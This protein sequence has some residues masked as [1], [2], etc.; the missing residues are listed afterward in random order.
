[1]SKSTVQ[2]PSSVNEAESEAGLAA[3]GGSECG[4]C[5]NPL[6]KEE[7]EYPWMSPHGESVCERCEFDNYHFRCCICD[8]HELKEHQH[9][10]LAVFD[11]DEV[12]S[13]EKRKAG[14]YQITGM[15]Y[16]ADGMIEGHVFEDRLKYVAPLPDGAESDWYP[17]GH[18]CRECVK[19][20]VTSTQNNRIS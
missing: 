13:D 10:I 17:A 8:E 20:H 5:G 16:Y 15:P 18:L 14:L 4:D 1:M 7:R 19:K 9:K 2:Q 6:T 3:S 12:F 11:A